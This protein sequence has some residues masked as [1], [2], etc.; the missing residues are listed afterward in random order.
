MLTRRL[1]LGTGA[2]AVLGPG[3]LGVLP[4]VGLPAEAASVPLARRIGLASPGLPSS[5][6]A[7]R[8]TSGA[9]GIAPVSATFFMSWAGEPA[10]PAD[11]VRGLARTRSV[12]VLTWEPWDPAGGPEQPAYRLARIAAGRHDAYLRR[13][14]RELRRYEGRVVLRLMHEPNGSW[15]PWAVG[16]NGNTPRDYVRAWRHVHGVL[17]DAG[18]RNVGLRFC[19]CSATVPGSPRWE[20][21][22]PGDRF[23]GSVGV[24]AYNFGTSQGWSHWQSFRRLVAPTA[25]RFATLSRRPLHVDETA[26]AEQGGDK[27]AWVRG[28][29]AHLRAHPEVRTAT[30]FDFAKEADWRVL[31]SDRSLQAF[32]AALHA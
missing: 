2:S 3:L 1:L 23:V 9:L 13:F 16:V 12:P 32:R 17:A 18:A 14:A 19:V 31:S 28:M 6:Q 15:Y 10:F 5:E 26:C 7:F 21:Y 29:F 30:W 4:D 8:E 20:R 11:L 27:A 22:Y 25:E 24:D